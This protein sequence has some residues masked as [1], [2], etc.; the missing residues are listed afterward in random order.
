MDSLTKQQE[1]FCDNAGLFG[2]MMS[3]A[4]LAQQVFFMSTHWIGF[5]FIAVY[6]LCIAGFVMLMKKSVSA[7]RMLLISSVLTF[8]VEAYMLLALTFSL[9][10][11]L[12]LM[13]IIVIVVLLY[14]GDIQK[15]LKQRL[16]AEKEEAAKWNGIL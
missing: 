8:L 6:L 14:M 2:V 7:L 5:T 3:I 15:R 16:I 12:L 9:V 1:S 10:L 4:C 11:L 13:Y